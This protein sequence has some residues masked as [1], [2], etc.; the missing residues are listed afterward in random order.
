MT[1]LV[2]QHASIGTTSERG[3]ALLTFAIPRGAVASTVAMPVDL[4]A[5]NGRVTKIEGALAAASQVAESGAREDAAHAPL[6][7]PSQALCLHRL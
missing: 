2:E 6:S 7:P 3:G 1:V 5:P 4:R